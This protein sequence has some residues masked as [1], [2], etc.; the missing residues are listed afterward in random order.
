[1]LGMIA[2]AASISQAGAVDDRPS[3]QCPVRYATTYVRH[4]TDLPKQVRDDLLKDGEIAEP[5]QPF[6]AYDSIS[7]PS[8]PRARLVLAGQS[9]TRWFVW[10]DRGG[11]N[12]RDQVYGYRQLWD[13]ADHFDWN[14]DAQLEGDPCIGINAF[15][16]GVTTPTRPN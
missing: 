3:P 9:G 6:E 2:M 7:D 16:D 11:F 4:L 13:K 5:D 8:L 12:R 15:L 10:I 14:R 1:M